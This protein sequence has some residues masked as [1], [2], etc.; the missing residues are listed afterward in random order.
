MGEAKK[1]LRNSF[2]GI[3]YGFNKRNDMLRRG[4]QGF[5]AAGLGAPMGAT[6]SHEPRR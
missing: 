6:R 5:D 4:F 2:R 1:G 3:I